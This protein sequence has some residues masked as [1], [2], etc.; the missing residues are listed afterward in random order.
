[1]ILS[2]SSRKRA[3]Y[4]LVAPSWVTVTAALAW[5]GAVDSK[6]AEPV[7][8]ASAVTVTRCAVLQLDGVK[9]RVAPEDT[10]RPELPL[11]R[12][13][14]T[15]TF[16][17]GCL[18]SF[19]SNVPDSPCFTPSWDGLATTAGP[20]ATV[21]PTG[22][23]EAEAPRLS[24]ALATSEWAPTARPPTD[25]VNGAEVSVPSSSVSS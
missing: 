13:V 22:V 7:P 5:P 23:E 3:S 2:Y 25:S 1:M 12:A 15:V 14:V 21:M 24:Y 8:E 20:E 4:D 16:S 17:L 19:T 10:D 11:A 9:V 18:D 6:T